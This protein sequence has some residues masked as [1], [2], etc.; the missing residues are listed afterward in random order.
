MMNLS[1]IAKIKTSLIKESVQSTW[2]IV[3]QSFSTTLNALNA[4]NALSEIFS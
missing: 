4:L 1:L 3:K 2:G